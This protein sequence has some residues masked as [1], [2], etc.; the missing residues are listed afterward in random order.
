MNP[1][2]LSSE[3]MK[4]EGINSYVIN[5]FLHMLDKVER[6][7]R[8]L[9]RE[10]DIEPV[11]ELTKYEDL[12]KYKETGLKNLNKLVFGKLNGGLGTGMGLE[13]AKSLLEVKPNLTIIDGFF[14]QLIIFNKKYN[15][16]IP[17]LL[18]NSFNTDEDTKKYIKKY[19]E[20]KTISFVQ[21]K[22]PKIF[23]DTLHPAEHK[24]N[25]L[26][27]NP[28][29]H[30]DIYLAM[31]QTGILD[32]LL[33]DGFK[34]LFMSNGDNLG[35]VIDPYVFGYV[36]EKKI[37]FLM[38]AV[39]RTPSD[40]KGGH[41][42][43]YKKNNQLLLREI[44]QCHEDDKEHFQDITRHKY[45]NAN[46]LWIN[47]VVLKK[48]LKKHDNILPMP[49]LVNEKNVNPKD[50]TSKKVYQ[51]ETAMG[52]AI[53]LFNGAEAIVTPKKRFAPIKKCSNLLEIWSDIYVINDMKQ[54]VISE[55]R[56]LPPIYIELDDKYYQIYNDFKERFNE[57]PSLINCNTLKVNGDVKFGKG[58][59]LKGNVVIINESGKQHLL[60]SIVIENKTIKID[61][62]GEIKSS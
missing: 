15:V 16:K 61:K 37:P 29:G 46:L 12:K 59:V 39:D 44:A 13:K 45:F 27:W 41:L 53:E 20:V 1:R 25:H 2:E 33:N 18:M 28:P 34:Y 9:T 56:T 3:K 17:L 4:N 38:E 50:K 58:V 42:A 48:L 19:P 62:N 55:K 31:M 6:G 40:T 51:I 35:A 32:K 8:G 11:Q 43:K 24:Y 21:N 47:L 52:S 23:T 26:E 10:K 49:M 60:E 54:L 30:G 5:N 57:V 36:I 22:H 7:H 14:E